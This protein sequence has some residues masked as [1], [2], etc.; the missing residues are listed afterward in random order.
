VV[1]E[2]GK[3]VEAVLEF[4]IDDEEIVRRLAAGRYAKAARRRILG[5]SQ[6]ASATSATVY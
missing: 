5:A 3:K 1:K 4:D 2:L 6:A